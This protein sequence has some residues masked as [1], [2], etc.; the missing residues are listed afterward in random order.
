MRLRD[1]PSERNTWR[2]LLVIVQ[3]LDGKSAYY[4]ACNEDEWQWDHPTMLAAASVDALNRLVWM[5]T[6]DGT[7]GRNPPKPVPRPGV[8]DDTSKKHGDKKSA[9]SVAD[10]SE[11]FGY[12]LEAMMVR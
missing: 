3:N 11:K 1:F 5:K 10:L 6:E 8:K 12:D 2:D 7:K 9:M 4:R